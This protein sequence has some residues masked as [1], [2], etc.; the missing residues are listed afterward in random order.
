MADR[1]R[2]PAGPS[3]ARPAGT[4]HA[5]G[6]IILLGEHAAVYGAPA[7]AAPVPQLTVTATARPAAEGHDRTALTA[8]QH[9]GG[10][11]DA[12]R[13]VL[14]TFRT[15]AGIASARRVELRVDCAVPLGRGLGSSAACARAVVLALGDL[16]GVAL[17]EGTVFDLVQVAERVVHGKASGVDAVAT[18]AHTLVLFRPRSRHGLPVA[19]GAVPA[20]WSVVVADSGT[21][22][23]TGEAVALLSERFEHD[24]GAG[25]RFVRAATRLVRAALRDLAEGDLAGLGTRLTAYHVLL[26]Q[27]GLSTDRIDALVD[28][29]L[30]AGALGAKLTGGGLGGC[31]IALAADA[32]AAAR[33]QTA[34]QAAGAT[35]TWTVAGEGMVSRAH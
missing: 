15:T 22:G 24:S 35:R 7:L 33:V 14:S 20:G 28:G 6:K 10:E 21:P 27:L 12:L 11:Q 4:G 3:P 25:P 34:L 29:A 23:H 19:C 16:F 30:A 1:T 8:P 17:D 9:P 18:G 2:S 31:A 5:H 26:R 13:A 32:A